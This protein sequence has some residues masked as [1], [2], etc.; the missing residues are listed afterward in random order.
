MSDNNIK[1]ILDMLDNVQEKLLALPDDMLLE[2]DARDNES[3]KDGV[4]FI[5]DYNDD[6]NEFSRLAVELKRR[7]EHHFTINAE[8]DEIETA[9]SPQTTRE[10]IIAELDR[11]TPHSLEESFTYK[12][13]FGFIMGEAAYKGLKT[14]KSLYFNILT[15]L[16]KKDSD[17]IGTLPEAEEL[18]SSRGNKLFSKDPKDLRVP[19]KP[20]AFDF[21]IEINL[22]AN[23][24]VDNI[25]R[26]F[27][28]FQIPPE[29]LKIY[30]REDRDAE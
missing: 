2:I 27:A 26:L 30:L 1:Q 12:R 11:T 21:H 25:K 14:W 16:A 15:E 17:K 24:I 28:Y 18:L 19:E 13:P 5:M 20:E 8:T 3:L 22:S 9:D 7:I 29:S 10:R 4:D 6:L 23:S